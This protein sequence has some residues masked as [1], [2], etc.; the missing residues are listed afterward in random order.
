M[1]GSQSNLDA[2]DQLGLV[3]NLPGREG[4][5]VVDQKGVE[6][7]DE[8]FRDGIRAVGAKKVDDALEGCHEAGRCGKDHILERTHAFKHVGVA[9]GNHKARQKDSDV[10][11]FERSAITGLGNTLDAVEEGLG[12]CNDRL[13]PEEATKGLKAA[14]DSP[15]DDINKSIR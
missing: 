14:K 8:V 12:G 10:E 1:E 13:G 9:V 15:S 3:G 11:V 6:V 2:F 7:H 4:L 5:D